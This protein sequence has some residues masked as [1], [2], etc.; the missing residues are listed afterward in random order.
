MDGAAARCL[1]DLGNV[2]V[3]G[4]CVSNAACVPNP[5]TA[6]YQTTC[7]PQGTTALCVCDPGHAPSGSGCDPFPIFDCAIVHTTGNPDSFEPDE[8]PDNATSLQLAAIWHEGHT[9]NPEG[10]VD[11]FRFTGTA[12]H[13]YE[14]RANSVDVDLYV[15]TYASD[16]VSSLGADHRGTK[17]ATVWFRAPA[18]GALYGRI[19]AF[20]GNS[21]GAYEVQVSDIGVDDYADVPALALSIASDSSVPGELQFDSDRDVVKLPLRATIA[22]SLAFEFVGVGT[23]FFEILAADGVTVIQ[24]LSGA[25]VSTVTRSP[26][27]AG[28]FLRVSGLTANTL[29]TFKITV[30]TLG[31]DDHGDVAAEATP[32]LASSSPV[33]VSMERADD[34]DVLSFEAVAPNIYSFSCSITGGF[35]SVNLALSDETGGVL[36]Q[37]SSSFV[38]EATESGKRFIQVRNDFGGTP[39]LS[40]KLQ[41]LGP[42][43]HGD[44]VADSTPILV[45]AGASAATLETFDDRDV[46]SFTAIEGHV[47]RFDCSLSPSGNC[48]TRVL[49]P[50][51]AEEAMGPSVAWETSTAGTYYLEVRSYWGSEIGTYTYVLTD[52]GMDDHGDTFATASALGLNPP[53]QSGSL[54]EPSDKD[55]FSFQ[56]VE[57]HIYRVSCTALSGA[58]C[59]VKVFASSGALIT[60]SDPYGFAPAVVAYEAGAAG[61]YYVEVSMESSSS[62]GTDYTYSVEDLGIDD[63]GDDV[64][65]ASPAS[66]GDSGAAKLEFPGDV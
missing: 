47:Y 19:Q 3:D 62:V 22:Y 60:S 20:R 45:G 50:T 61:T 53:P 28:V 15:D 32:L 34:V 12:R 18:N 55:V 48:S 36:S 25:R 27:D 14:M 23:P 49:S 5:C 52:L 44:T 21:V 35:G 65:T 37:T 26:S 56:A 6:Q 42:D 63:H 10:D 4:L 58:H 2:E 54:E 38:Y 43:D 64:S 30:A 59:G 57:L 24:K 8:C 31:L 40:C 46:F 1:C 51:G 41:N 13:I 9:L 39:R 66:V 17:S 11:W 7:I 33:A 16:G 29:G